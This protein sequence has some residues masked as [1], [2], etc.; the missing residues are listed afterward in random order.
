[1]HTR[2]SSLSQ[3]LGQAPAPS[4]RLVPTFK[5]KAFPDTGRYDSS[6]RLPNLDLLLDSTLERIKHSRA[7]HASDQTSFLQIWDKVCDK[8]CELKN[9]SSYERWKTHEDVI[10]N[11]KW[12]AQF[13]NRIAAAWGNKRLDEF[14]ALREE[15]KTVKPKVRATRDDALEIAVAYWIEAK[16]AR[17]DLDDARVLHALIECHLYIGIT[18]STKSESESKSDAGKLTG[19]SAR[20]EM[21]AVAIEVLRNM[22]VDKKMKKDYLWEEVTKIIHSTPKY[23]GVLKDYDDQTKAGKK[24]VEPIFYRLTTT[25]K[26]WSAKKD[27]KYQELA[28]QY[29]QVCQRIE[30]LSAQDT[31]R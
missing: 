1:M 14:D 16:N 30:Q 31:R 24:D 6:E 27:P 11:Q 19:L 20:D 12:L 23:A 29:R 9:A 22:Q 18:Q 13:D 10:K 7:S 26:R 8:L 25:L 5:S 28:A 3:A 2:P 17:N 15:R 4:P 21:V